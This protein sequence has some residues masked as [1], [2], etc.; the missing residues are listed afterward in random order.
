MLKNNVKNKFTLLKSTTFGLLVFMYGCSTTTQQVPVVDVQSYDQSYPNITTTDNS[1]I[2]SGYVNKYAVTDN[3]SSNVSN[4]VD[5]KQ[6]QTTYREKN[7]NELTYKNINIPKR[8]DGKPDYTKISKGSYKEE[9]YRT[10]QGDS[11]FLIS[12][13]SGKSVDEIAQLN[14][15]TQPYII[16][17]NEIIRL[18]DSKVANVSNVAVAKVSPPAVVKTNKA[19]VETINK[20]I[21]PNNSY[22][23]TGAWIWPTNGSVIQKFGKGDGGNKGIDISGSKGQPILAAD[24]GRVAYAGRDLNGYGNLIILR[25]GDA[26][27]STY[28]HNDTILVKKDQVVTRGQKIATM[29]DTDADRSKLH[30]EIRRRGESVDPLIYLPK[31]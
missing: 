29:G 15:M 2:D 22:A 18:K 11:L 6:A 5:I 13:I 30:F 27:L 21:Q 1:A 19:K 25:H 26:F 4:R 16:G 3:S 20:K 31:K 14:N 10:K 8:A 12:Y 28:A 9:A 7:L 23:T 17:E 24:S